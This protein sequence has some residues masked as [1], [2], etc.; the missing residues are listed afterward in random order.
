MREQANWLSGSVE[1]EADVKLLRHK[2]GWC[3][4]ST[5]GRREKITVGREGTRKKGQR[6][7]QRLVYG[8]DFIFYL[9]IIESFQRVC[10][11]HDFCFKRITDDY[12]GK[13]LRG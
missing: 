1:G 10:A 8:M 3:I 2:R 12:M 11:R 4:P 5:S 6:G 13:R 9:K 7:S